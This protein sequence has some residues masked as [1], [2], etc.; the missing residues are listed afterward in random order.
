MLKQLV[1]KVLGTR[2]ER[3]LKRIQPVV[4]AIRK[5][6]ERLKALPDADI[7]AQTA[8]FRE[9]L[10][11]RTGTLATEVA[12][13]KQAKHDCPDADER[14]AIDRKLVDAEKRLRAETEAVLHDILPEALATVR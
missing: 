7:Q 8:K 10:Q 2:F 1:T 11:Q 13:L 9:V 14:A 3:E 4:D 5:H 12:G 6:E